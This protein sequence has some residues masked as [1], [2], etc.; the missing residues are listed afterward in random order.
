MIIFEF[1][2]Y[3]FD[4]S[5]QFIIWSVRLYLFYLMINEIKFRITDFYYKIKYKR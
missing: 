5:L 1:M 2:R 4:L 3:T